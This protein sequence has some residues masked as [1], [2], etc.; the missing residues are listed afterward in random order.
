MNRARQSA[1]QFTLPVGTNVVGYLNSEKGVGEQARSA[2]RVIAAA[3]I[4]H[5][6]N[7][8]LD[9]GSENLEALPASLSTDNPFAINLIVVNP[10]QLASF[11]E[12]RLS[13]F[14]SR[15]NIGYWAWE[16]SEFPKE[17]I[18]AFDY[19]DEVWTVSQFARD[20]IAASSPVPVQV[21]HNALD[22][23]RGGELAYERLAFGVAEETFLFL[24]FFDFHSMIERKNPI[25][26]VKA[27]K[28]AFG[29]RRDVQLLIKSSHG[30]EHRDELRMLNEASSGANV[31]ILDEVL[32]GHAKDCLMMAA[33]CYV[34]LHRS[35]GF[36]LT[37]AEAMLFGKPAVATDYSG[38]C[39]F[40]SA[41]TGFP[42]PY[43]LVSIADDHGP[44]HA[45]QQ[46]AE[47]DLDYAADVLRYIER[48]RVAANQ[49]G[50]R[51]R[52][53]VSYQLH[54]VTIGKNVKHRIEELG[55]I[56]GGDDG[57]IPDSMTADAS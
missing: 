4:P 23:R 49:V 50:R 37:I 45:G 3:K 1:N 13:Y 11:A 10:E 18:S 7:N 38:N 40:L 55:F 8:L 53:H 57:V 34:S 52:A 2:L 28:R 31:R 21:V 54:P 44:Y 12:T 9:T 33:D 20:S 42:I 6:A 19:V 36:G 22:I 15:F 56:P 17:W 29:S 25:G 5:V 16:L 14:E 51:A 27:F 26:L 32:S 30:Q 41:E 39:D 47:P 24:F 43:K 48:N 35:E 46:W